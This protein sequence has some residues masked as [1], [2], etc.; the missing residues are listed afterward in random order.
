MS[1]GRPA[2]VAGTARPAASSMDAVDSTGVR[3]A[4]A[5]SGVESSFWTAPT[6]IHDATAR[7]TDARARRKP[8][9]C[10][11]SQR[12]MAIDAS[13]LAAVMIAS[14]AA[15]GA[16][17]ASPLPES[18]PS[19]ASTAYRPGNA[20]AIPCTQAGRLSSGTATPPMMSIGRNTAWPSAC[21]AGTVSPIIVMS[22][23]M[24]RNAADVSVNAIQSWK[25]W[26]GSGVPTTA[27][28]AICSA[29]AESSSK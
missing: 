14:A 29:P 21:A 11:A 10:P 13:P 23:P 6:A 12:K 27:A 9:R 19:M 16:S 4:A 22:R 1:D 7:P 8:I 26:D 25:R 5:R 17:R 3:C 24:P 18:A 28:A 2:V 20:A 15:F